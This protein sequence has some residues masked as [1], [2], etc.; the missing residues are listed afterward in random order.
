MLPYDVLIE[1]A[2][3]RNMP[4]DKSRG[5][6]REY[7]QVSMLKQ[8]YRTAAGKKIYFTGGTY[9]RLAHGLKRFSEDLDF[10]SNEVTK[11]GFEKMCTM[12]VIELNR[13]GIKSEVSFSHWDHVLV[14]RFNFPDTEQ[15][16]GIM[17]EH[18]KSSGLLI[19][20]EVNIPKW[21][22]KHET[23][24]ISGY[25]ETYPCVCT[26]KSILFADKIDAFMKKKMGRHLF[27]IVF[28]LSQKF[29]VDH[30]ILKKLG[31]KEK[32]FKILLASIKNLSGTELK[33]QADILR[34]FLFDEQEA[35]SIINA[36]LIVEKLVQKYS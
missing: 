27:D 4:T 33:K 22:I 15:F 13:L 34:P 16:Y 28:M 7:L 12:L 10:N 26:E 36:K 30:K 5:V 3:L 35:D 19:K 6:L 24:V 2:K 11:R 29:T 8:I 17:T 1:Q 20:V 32:P 14:S 31:H 9:L 18:T 23:E 21:K 25:G